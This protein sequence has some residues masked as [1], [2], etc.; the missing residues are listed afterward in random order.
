[1]ISGQNITPEI[2]SDAALSSLWTLT[3]R[4]RIGTMVTLAC[5]LGF[6]LVMWYFYEQG[7]ELFDQW[8]NKEQL[9]VLLEKG[10]MASLW[11]GRAVLLLLMVLVVWWPFRK[12][13]KAPI[14]S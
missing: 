5:Y 3:N 2:R 11:L 13:A 10:R 9:P 1:M 7:F 8:Q 12:P 4:G 6:I 14:T